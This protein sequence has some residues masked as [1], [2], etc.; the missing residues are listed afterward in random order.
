MKWTLCEIQGQVVKIAQTKGYFVL[1]NNFNFTNIL[2]KMTDKILKSFKNIC[3]PEEW[4]FNLKN[5]LHN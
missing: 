5:K 3:L 1:G 4:S 2:R